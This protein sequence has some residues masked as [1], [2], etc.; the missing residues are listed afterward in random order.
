MV[1]FKS[2]ATNH[3]NNIGEP[4]SNMTLLIRP[5]VKRK[6][7]NKESTNHKPIIKATLLL[8]FDE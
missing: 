2:L 6:F 7:Q 8:N 4:I 3:L 1:G 5:K